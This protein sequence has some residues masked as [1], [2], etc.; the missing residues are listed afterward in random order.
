MYG[1]LHSPAALLAENAL[2]DLARSFTPRIQAFG[3]TPVL[4]DLH[5]LGRVFP[6]QEALGHAILDA[7]RERALE[8]NLSLSHSRVAAL[9][10]ARAQAGLSIVALGKEAEALAPLSLRLLE[11]DEDR[12]G[13]F[14]RWGLRTF[15]DLQALPSSGLFE[16]LGADGPRL[17]RLARGEDAQPLVP[18]ALPEA[19]E[20]RLEIEW[21]VDGL[22]PL[23]FLLT[24]VLEPLCA[25]LVERGRKAVTLTIQYGLVDGNVHERLLKPLAA[26]AEP[27]T[28]RTL[29]LLDLEAHPPRD[30]IQSLALCA[31]STPAR[32]VQFSLLD[33]AQASPE[34]L[35]ETLARLHEWTRD[36]KSG[37]ALVLDTHRPGA[38]LVGSF[39]PG[40]ATGAVRDAVSPLLALRAFRPPLPASVRSKDGAPE[41]LSASRVSGPVVDRAGP[42]CVSSDWWDV[43]FSRDEWD[44]LLASGGLYRIYRD[45]LR[46][47]W[48]V[49]GELD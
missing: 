30:A 22:E 18:T 4:M 21:P 40:P 42:W 5:G 6:T 11:L 46:D 31:V 2:A 23:A 25:K 20:M 34:K 43:A 49:A 16:R 24:R 47:A 45:R 48:F 39:A 29:A 13:L 9:V 37:A 33:P 32:R 15:G 3:A 10:L 17:V 19:F 38:F 44:V 8:A 14:A 35:A 41:F 36:G 12:A 28:W 1:G 27:R 7:A 26:S